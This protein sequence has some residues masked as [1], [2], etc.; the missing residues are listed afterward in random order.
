[1]ICRRG[2]VNSTIVWMEDKGNSFG[3]H[4]FLFGDILYLYFTNILFRIGR[5]AGRNFISHR[6]LNKSRA[7]NDFFTPMPFL[8]LSVV[9][10]KL[11][12]AAH[13]VSSKFSARL[14]CA[15]DFVSPLASCCQVAILVSVVSSH[16]ATRVSV[17]LA[18]A[19]PQPLFFGPL[20]P[21]GKTLHAC[22]C[23]GLRHPCFGAD[24]SRSFLGPCTQPTKRHR[25]RAPVSACSGHETLSSQQL[26][27]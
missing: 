18:P 11:V 13:A 20:D 14:L 21:T 7:E 17:G 6:G 9:T 8:G 5:P 25:S 22:P 27:A 1:V 26:P 4:R 15:G 19:G 16:Q 2:I 24:P 10:D 3:N 12:L 23:P